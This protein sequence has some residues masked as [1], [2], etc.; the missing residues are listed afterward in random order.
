MIADYYDAINI[1][2]HG[3]RLNWEEIAKHLGFTLWWALKDLAVVISKPSVIKLDDNLKLH[4]EGEP[5][6]EYKQE[7]IIT[8][9]KLKLYAYHGDILPERYGSTHPTN[10]QARWLSQEKDPKL[11]WILTKAIGYHKLAQEFPV[12]EVRTWYNNNF[13]L[14]HKCT[15]LRV[16]NNSHGIFFLKIISFD[17]NKTY[18]CLLPEDIFSIRQAEIWVKNSIY[19]ELFIDYVIKQLIAT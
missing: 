12:L 10:W 19:S 16:K 13:N 15:L 3:M 2:Y 4:A 11:K 18:F 17:K 14:F 9:E 6:L 5:A 7:S 1:E 8:D